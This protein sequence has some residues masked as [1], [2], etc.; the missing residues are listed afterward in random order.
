VFFVFLSL[1]V[2]LGSVLLYLAR[3]L[4]VLVNLS[5]T[6]TISLFDSFPS[7]FLLSAYP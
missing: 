1:R 2:W 3:M 4:A 7:E 5:F 6:L